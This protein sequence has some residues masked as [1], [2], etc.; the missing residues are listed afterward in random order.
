MGTFWIEAFGYLGSLLVIVSMLMTSV[1]KLRIINT[2]GSVV[3][4]IYGIIIRAYPTVAMN[5]VLIAIN[6]YNLWRLSGNT[7]PDYHLEM[8]D[9]RDASVQFLLKKYK[10]D[11]VKYFTD[12]R[13]PEEG[14][15]AYLVMNGDLC[16]GLLLGTLED[17]TLRFN[18]DYTTP[19][20]RDFSIGQFL[21]GKLREDGV[22][23]LVFLGQPGNHSGYL[24]R[25]E[26]VPVDGHYERILK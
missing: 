5:A 12:F 16:V 23:R 18:L 3:C 19:G 4:V 21:Y 1:L 20:Y 13:G 11:M 22:Q 9:I 2:L 10:E 17:G 15:T 6:L 25:M 14:Q 7:G 24:K 26:F 8:A